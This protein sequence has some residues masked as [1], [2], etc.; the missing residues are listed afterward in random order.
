MAVQHLSASVSGVL[1][2]HHFGRV[3]HSSS[4]SIWDGKPFFFTLC[5]C[6]RYCCAPGVCSQTGFSSK[7]NALGAAVLRQTA[8]SASTGIC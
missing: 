7:H 4:S 3:P 6:Y 1:Q 8:L 2:G 5:G